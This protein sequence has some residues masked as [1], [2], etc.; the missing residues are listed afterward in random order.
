MPVK[1][2]GVYKIT[3]LVNGKCYVGSSKDA[4]S[5]IKEHFR[6]LEKGCH[7]NKHLQA[8]FGKYGKE[9]WGHE[10]LRICSTL[11]LLSAEQEFIDILHPEY[12]Q[13][14][15][16]GSNL[17]IKFGPRS[18]ETIAKISASRMG[19]PY[20]PASEE[21]NARRSAA[22]RSRCY[23]GRVL[24]EETKTKIGKSNKI[25][26]LGNKNACGSKGKHYGSQ[27][28]DTKLKKSI[29]ITAWRRKRK[30]KVKDE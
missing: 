28:E 23:P 7:V 13:A 1:T 29:S 25:A 4:E 14:P 17:G 24:S 30:E 10:I 26:M 19:H 11:E 9:G 18:E 21:G 20:Y 15:V 5:R 22:S 3:N 8:S 12:N 6:N 27:S 16:A 2:S